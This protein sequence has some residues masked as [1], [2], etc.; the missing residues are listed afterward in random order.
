MHAISR[1]TEVSLLPPGHDAWVEGDEP[2]VVI[3]IVI[4]V[5]YG[6]KRD[7]SIFAFSE[8]PAMSR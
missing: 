5:L 1:K 8:L 3:D 4:R 6:Q 7:G 2:S